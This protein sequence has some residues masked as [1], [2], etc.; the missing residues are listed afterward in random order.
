MYSNDDIPLLPPTSAVPPGRTARQLETERS[1]K[2]TLC[3]SDTRYR[4]PTPAERRALLIGFAMC[5]KALA[6]SAFDAVRLDTDVDLTDPEAIAQKS[7]AIVLIEVKS[8]NR[9]AIGQDLA[10]Y[11]FNITSAELLVAQALGSQYRFAFVNTITGHCQELALS[12]VMARAK[13]IYPAFHI[14]L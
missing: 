6:G 14:K 11:F 4:V 2:Q 12:E 13:A 8:T 3:D 10:G 5:G 9:S 7:A 1:A